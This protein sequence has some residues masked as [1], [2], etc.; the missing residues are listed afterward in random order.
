MMMRMDVGRRIRILGMNSVGN[1]R[2][3]CARGRADE[4][5]EGSNVGYVSMTG[6]RYQLH[7]AVADGNFGKGQM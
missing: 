5:M 3:V 4:G 6:R 2:V 1:G 7:V